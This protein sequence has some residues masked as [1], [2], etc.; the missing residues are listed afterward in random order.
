MSAATE[1]NDRAS[2][3]AR[4]LEK[5]IGPARVHAILARAGA[6][7]LRARL[8]QKEPAEG[9]RALIVRSKK[10]AAPEAK[11]TRPAPD[12]QLAMPSLGMHQPPT[13]TAATGGSGLVGSILHRRPTSAKRK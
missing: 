10:A 11:V 13:L 3:A 7:L 12:A 5:A 2:D 1:I 8:A 9:T 6:N 4:K